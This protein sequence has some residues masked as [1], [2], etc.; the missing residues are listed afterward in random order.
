MFIIQYYYFVVQMV[1]ALAIGNRLVGFCVSLTYHHYCGFFLGL[2]YF[3]HLQGVIA[4][5]V[6]FLP[7]VLES[8]ISLRSLVCIL[9]YL[10]RNFILDPNTGS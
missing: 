6:Y 2:P 4:H 10:M 7:P 1:P 8:A 5:C 9:F 3:Q